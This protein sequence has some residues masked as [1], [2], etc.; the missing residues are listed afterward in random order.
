MHVIIKKE[1]N[2]KYT[3]GNYENHENIRNPCEHDANHE[4][5]KNQ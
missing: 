2:Q 4:N 5:P 3:Y 1:N